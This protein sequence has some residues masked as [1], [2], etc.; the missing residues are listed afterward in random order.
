MFG[1]LLFKEPN[2]ADWEFINVSKS[3]IKVLNSL[4]L[5]KVRLS[6]SKIW[7]TFSSESFAT[8]VNWLT[9][10]VSC[11]AGKGKTPSFIL[12]EVQSFTISSSVLSDLSSSWI[13]LTFS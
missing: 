7:E 13:F 1:N 3:F 10:F 12:E 8:W 2:N 11:S 6:T 4:L 9:T 5:S